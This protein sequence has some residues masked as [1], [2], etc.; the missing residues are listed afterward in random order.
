MEP[1]VIVPVEVPE[2]GDPRHKNWAKT[3]INVDESKTTGY[4]FEG[5]WVATG[6]I[7]DIPAPSILLVYGEKGSR[8]NPQIH[9]NVYV[10]NT[11]GT[12]SL[13]ESASGRAWARTLRDP[14]V[15][16]LVADRPIQPASRP[17]DPALM[18]Y[19]DDALT[20]EIERRA[21]RRT[22]G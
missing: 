22:P 2:I 4:A 3:I 19:S 18:S 20:D 15:E 1:A 9:A 7:Q 6:G 5:D 21:S 13:R 11:D 14:V 8:A 16:L 12:L 10:A 17:W